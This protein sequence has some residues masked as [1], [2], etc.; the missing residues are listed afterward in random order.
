MDIEKN[1]K[2][3]GF[4][5]EERAV[6]YLL[7]QGFKI[8]ERNL[9]ER[10]GEVDILALK[11]ETFHFVEVKSGFVLEKNKEY[12]LSEKIDVQ[13]IKRIERVALSYLERVGQEDSFWCIDLIEVYFSTNGRFLKIKMM[14]NVTL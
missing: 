5:G 13:K 6:S 11:D 7:S 10:Y 8:L 9:K 4:L 2:K 3:K 1:K 14:E 12:L